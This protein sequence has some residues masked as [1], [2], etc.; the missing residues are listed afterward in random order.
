VE[1]LLHTILEHY[2]TGQGYLDL[3]DVGKKCSFYGSNGVIEKG[4]KGNKVSEYYATEAT[5]CIT[6]IYMRELRTW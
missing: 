2:I 3:T 4:M 1:R 6:Q 5:L